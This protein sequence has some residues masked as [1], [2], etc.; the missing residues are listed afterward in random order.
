MSH[1]MVG[2]APARSVAALICLAAILVLARFEMRGQSLHASSPLPSFEVAT[3]KLSR[4]GGSTW[5]G[6]TEHIAQQCEHANVHRERI[7]PGVQFRPGFRR[8]G[9]DRYQL[10]LY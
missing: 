5:P 3:I 2:R 1:Q 4:V 9:V 7:Q 8:A 6:S 10:V